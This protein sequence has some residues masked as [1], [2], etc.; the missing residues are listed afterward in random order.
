MMVVGRAVGGLV[1]YRV[2]LPAAAKFGIALENTENEIVIPG[3][4]PQAP[5]E[6]LDS[7]NDHRIAMALAAVC[8]RTGGVLDGAEA[9]RKSLPDYWDRLA[10]LGIQAE[11]E[12]WSGSAGKIS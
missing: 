9:V 6:L 1:Q 2:R 5:A 4:A 8:V 7:H 3:R 11:V 12:P 10:G